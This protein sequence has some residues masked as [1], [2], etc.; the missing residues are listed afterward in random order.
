MLF[1]LTEKY[2][3]DV[4][5]RFGYDPYNTS[6]RFFIAFFTAAWIRDRERERA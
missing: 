6:D 4:N 1:K 2:V 5:C 3:R